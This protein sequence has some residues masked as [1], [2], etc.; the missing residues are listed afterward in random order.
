MGMRGSGE[1]W[2]DCPSTRLGNDELMQTGTACA[3]C[4]RAMPK[5]GGWSV[6]RTLR[7]CLR[8]YEVRRDEVAD[9][10]RQVRTMRKHR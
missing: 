6:G 8:V 5:K 7:A 9:P 10:S 3:Q 4:C 2:G 1:Y